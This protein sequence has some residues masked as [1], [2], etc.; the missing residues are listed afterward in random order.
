MS[1]SNHFFDELGLED[2]GGFEIGIA[3]HYCF[4]VIRFC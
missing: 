2:F 4:S 3:H 1:L